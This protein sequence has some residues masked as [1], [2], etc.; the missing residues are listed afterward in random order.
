MAAGFAGLALCSRQLP[1]LESKYSAGE[2]KRLFKGGDRT[3]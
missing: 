1:L 3:I 2:P